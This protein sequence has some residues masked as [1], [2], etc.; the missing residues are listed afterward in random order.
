MPSRPIPPRPSLEFDQKQARAL[1]DAFR[2]GDRAAV[3]R[4]RALHP[5]FPAAGGGVALHDAQLVIAREYGFPSWPRWKQFVDARLLDTG[6]RAAALVRAACAGDMRKASVLLAAEPALERFDLYTAC[7]CGAAEHVARL[8]EGHPDLARSRG[9]PLDREP[10]LYACFSR[11]LRSDATRAAGIVRAVRLLLDGGADVNAHF[12]VVEGTETWIQPSLYGAVGIA[13]NAELTRMLLEAGAD[14]NELQAAPGDDGGAVSGGLEAL[15]HASEFADVTC[16]R[17]LLEA[18]PPVYPARVSYCLARMLDFENLPGV[19]LYLEH[20]ADPNFRIPWM[21]DRTHL[22]PAVV[23]GRSLAIVRRL[24]EA[25]GQPEAPD[26][27]RPAPFVSARRHPHAHLGRL[28]RAR[29]RRHTCVDPDGRE[30]AP[31]AA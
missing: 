16:L 21:H 9:G 14:V 13:N 10:I 26:C 20:G 28:R 24:V 19:D 11:F 17:L 3:E 27:L 25:G 31:G 30:A 6:Q 4:F 7:V 18:R 2:E 23:Y 22:H 15:Y 12:T 8:L 5:R 29:R 1:L